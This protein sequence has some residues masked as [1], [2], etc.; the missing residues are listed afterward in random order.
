M[1]LGEPS[2]TETNI[3]AL[4][5]VETYAK[6]T[7]QQDI[8]YV[9]SVANRTPYKNISIDSLIEKI[10][11]NIFI[12]VNFV[13]DRIC[14]NE[15]LVIENI[16]KQGKYHNQFKT[17]VTNGSLLA[18]NPKSVRYKLEHDLFNGI[19][20]HQ[21]S[22]PSRP[23]YGAL[24]LLKYANGAAPAYGSCFLTLKRDI[25]QKCTFAMLND[26]SET[27]R[28]FKGTDRFFYPVLKA[29][30]T[31]VLVKKHFLSKENYT[32]TKAIEYIESL[33]GCLTNEINKTI[34]Y[35]IEAHIHDIINFDKDVTSIHIDESYKNTVIS[36][37]AEKISQK[38]QINLFWIP[39]RKAPV[40]TLVQNS[41][42]TVRQLVSIISNRLHTDYINPKIL[43]D[44]YRNRI[45]TEDWIEFGDLQN[46]NQLLRKVWYQVI[47]FAI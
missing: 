39:E 17:G 5:Y 36:F 11:R 30:F 12:T 31:Q 23:I 15:K 41:D 46:F 2:M 27:N 24:N 13:P 9:Q 42:S 14:G 6:K 1:E 45:M 38:Y 28:P 40:S 25:Y 35:Y 22:S 33:N 20:D 47:Y 3:R 4:K 44:V 8:K 21:E 29:I 19:Y 37:I 10:F 32:V 34:Y 43:G 26:D 18:T 7:K 16:L